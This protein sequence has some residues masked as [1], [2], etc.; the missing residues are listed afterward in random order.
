MSEASNV[1][2]HEVFR[3]CDNTRYYD[4]KTCFES[5]LYNT[6]LLENAIIEVEP[7]MIPEA[8]KYT[9]YNCITITKGKKKHASGYFIAL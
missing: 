3:N 8:E 6:A 7:D 9:N 1:A 2:Q 4:G 5:V